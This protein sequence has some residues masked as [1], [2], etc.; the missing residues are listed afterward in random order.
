MSGAV[1]MDGVLRPDVANFLGIGL[2]AFIMV[3]AIDRGF[4]AIGR[5]QLTT[6]GS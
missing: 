2:V 6:S 4:R 1:I 5:P 3:W